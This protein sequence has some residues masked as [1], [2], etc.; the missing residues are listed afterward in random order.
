MVYWICNFSARGWIVQWVSRI[1]VIESEFADFLMANLRNRIRREFGDLQDEKTQALVH[2][3]GM[4]R[5]HAGDVRAEFK[6]CFVAAEHASAAL[7]L[8]HGI[9]EFDEWV[10]SRRFHFEFVTFACFQGDLKPFHAAA[11]SSCIDWVGWGKQGSDRKRAVG[12]LYAVAVE[13]SARHEWIA[14]IAIG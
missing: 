13:F 10:K 8:P 7:K 5:M 3:R 6:L 1:E 11:V 12:E 2:R 4:K 14:W 9:L